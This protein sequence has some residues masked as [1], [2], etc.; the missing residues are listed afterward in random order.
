MHE[1]L[2]REEAQ[3]GWIYQVHPSTRMEAQYHSRL[4]WARALLGEQR[5]GMALPSERFRDHLVL[6]PH[7]SEKWW[8]REGRELPKA[9][10]QQ[11]ACSELEP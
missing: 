2:C 4:C 9:T 8:L 3:D 11:L 7:L 5:S 1:K 6:R 10:Q